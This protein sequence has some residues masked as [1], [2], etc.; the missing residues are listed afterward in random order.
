MDSCRHHQ[1]RF[2]GRRP[3]GGK[4]IVMK[5]WCT[6]YPPY[7][8]EEPYLYLAFSD[9]DEKSLWPLV[10]ILLSRGCRIWY[11]PGPARD[12]AQTL[13][14]QARQRGAALVLVFSS[15]AAAADP[16]VK[17]SVLACQNAGLPLLCLSPDGKDRRLSMGL[18][19]DIPVISIKDHKTEKDLEGVL[20]RAEGFSQAL[21]GS[22]REIRETSVSSAL[23]LV[24]V[25]L[26]LLILG[27][28]LFLFAGGQRDREALRDQVVIQDPV[29]LSALQ[30]AAGGGPVTEDLVKGLSALDLDA[31]PG[32]WEDLSLLPALTEISLPQ[33]A[34]LGD[35][36]LPEGPY[37]I[38]LKGGAP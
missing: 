16:N 21:L 8:G 13:F 23:S 35:D 38:R 30:K 20:L 37:T 6:S 1:A 10:R 26:S 31:M 22:P 17:S 5:N 28:S 27:L 29:I 11:A 33:E 18:G 24:L 4:V 32:T 19:P 34:L 3:G 12:A 15:S 14:R 36:P 9:S 7:E 25:L 2:T